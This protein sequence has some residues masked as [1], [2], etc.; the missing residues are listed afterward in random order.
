MVFNLKPSWD[1]ALSP[2]SGMIEQD[3]KLINPSIPTEITHQPSL[4]AAEIQQ[5]KSS[6]S[7]FGGPDSYLKMHSGRRPNSTIR[8]RSQNDI[9]MVK[10]VGT[11]GSFAGA[12]IVFRWAYGGW[13]PAEGDLWEWFTTVPQAKYA[14]LLSLAGVVAGGLLGQVVGAMIKTIGAKN[15][16]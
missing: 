14:V 2:L 5:L 12:M 10:V 1:P 13:P 3:L 9:A 15:N 4:T 8:K 6:S 11:I 16:K 7:K